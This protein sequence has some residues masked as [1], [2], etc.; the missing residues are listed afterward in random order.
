MTDFT[1][2]RQQQP[3]QPQPQ[4]QQLRAVPV[5]AARPPYFDFNDIFGCSAGKKLS[6]P[7]TTAPTTTPAANGSGSTTATATT[8]TVNNNNNHSNNN[9]NGA[10][11]KQQQQSS[12]GGQ[13]LMSAATAGCCPVC[14]TA[15][16]TA[17]ELESH[18]IWELER[19]YKQAAAAGRRHR[20]GTP[21]KL[22]EGHHMHG[23]MVC[24]RDGGRLSPVAGGSSRDATLHG[25]W[26]TY[27]KVK[28]NRHNRLRIKNRKRKPD[29]MLLTP[30][31]ATCCCPVCSEP[32]AAATQEQMNAHVE[33][34]LRN[35][36]HPSVATAGNDDE[37]ENVD[38]EG[39]AETT[40][41][42]IVY[43]GGSSGWH[44]QQPHNRMRQ[45]QMLMHGGGYNRGA[46]AV[47]MNCTGPGNPAQQ[48]P[49]RQS[50]TGGEDSAGGAEDAV[51]VVD[52]N[53]NEN[54]GSSGSLYNKL[55]DPSAMDAM[56]SCEN[57][58]PLDVSI[59]KE[60]TQDEV[61]VKP[62]MDVDKYCAQ[63]NNNGQV[64]EALK[65]RIRELESVSKTDGDKFTC[66]LCKG[67]FKDPVVSTSCWHVY[68][69]V[70]WLQILGAKKLCPQCYVITLPSN[71]RRVYL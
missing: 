25:R 40:M 50:A 69:E 56:D 14:G 62:K 37:D 8:A 66:L 4:P 12:A 6:P 27:Q 2:A 59:K 15:L 58:G 1:S 36:G 26:E 7:M 32:V 64:V 45:Q 71:L 42:D 16:R 13:Q 35:K 55:N 33:M 67:N 63:F 70:C 48:P 57:V 5:T 17:H 61:T 68:C 44:G 47:A 28:A 24:P 34:C 39:D 3:Q 23:L 49:P 30:T 41:Y 60:N 38:V 46:A 9:N 51:L 29:E 22:G 43:G 21:D 20:R 53:D 31:P 54:G 65:A 52:D 18:F 11:I 19:L 10:S